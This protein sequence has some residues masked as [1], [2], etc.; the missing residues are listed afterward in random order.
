MT[1]SQKWILR[2][3]IS[4]FLGLGIFLLGYPQVSFELLE[5]I[6]LTLYQE[7]YKKT[8]GKPSNNGLSLRAPSG[9][10]GQLDLIMGPFGIPVA[11]S[12]LFEP[13]SWGQLGMTRSHSAHLVHE[14][15]ATG[16]AL[17]SSVPNLPFR[18]VVVGQV[19][20]LYSIYN[21]HQSP[22]TPKYTYAFLWD[23]RNEMRN[24]S[25][26]IAPILKTHAPESYKKLQEVILDHAFY[27][28]PDQKIIYGIAKKLYRLNDPH[29]LSTLSILNTNYQFFKIS[30]PVPASDLTSGKI[31]ISL[32]LSREGLEL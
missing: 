5:N 32:T 3:C 1:L 31:F 30:L 12:S 23:A 21:L 6:P 13:V 19:L 22:S 24:L 28:S 8:N 16:Y 18:G 9:V 15:P 7:I 10:P 11:K 4:I 27:I 25:A 14:Q 17:G 26:A 2:H 20:S 29:P